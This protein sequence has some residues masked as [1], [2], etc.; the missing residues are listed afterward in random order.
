MDQRCPYC[1]LASCEAGHLFSAG[2]PVT[3]YYVDGTRL[4][5]L[6][7][8]QLNQEA[9]K[10]EGELKRLEGAINLGCPVED[11]EAH[12]VLIAP[13]SRFSKH[14]QRFL[15]RLTPEVAAVC[16]PLMH[17]NPVD[18]AQQTGHDQT[19]IMG[20]AA[21]C[22][23]FGSSFKRHGRPVKMSWCT[24]NRKDQADESSPPTPDA[25]WTVARPA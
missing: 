11:V 22:H 2:D 6:M 21:A 4:K 10:H 3:P 16:V 9:V 24:F 14:Y 8:C 25:F 18:Y 15:E 7:R 5:P 12:A 23:D 20:V 1:K 19:S 13:Q 17:L